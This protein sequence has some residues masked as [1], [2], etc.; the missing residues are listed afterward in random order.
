MGGLSERARSNHSFARLFDMV[1]TNPLPDVEIQ[2]IDISFEVGSGVTPFL[3]ALTAETEEAAGQGAIPTEPSALASVARKSMKTLDQ[4]IARYPTFAPFVLAKARLLENEG[5]D[6][7]SLK[8]LSDSLAKAKTSESSIADYLSLASV[9]ANLFERLSQTDNAL[10]CLSQALN[11][12]EDLAL[13][14]QTNSTDQSALGDSLGTLAATYARLGHGPEACA[15]MQKLYAQRPEDTILPL[16]L[17]AWQVWFGQDAAYEALR[18]RLLDQAEGSDEPSTAERAAKVYCLR[19]STNDVML[20]KAL[21]LATRAVEMG[22][23]NSYQGWF[24]LALGMAEYR[25]GHYAAAE[26]ALVA[27]EPLPDQGQAL[28]CALLGF[29]ALSLIRQGRSA[30]ART[31]LNQAAA[32]MPPV[33]NHGAPPLQGGDLASHDVVVSWL[34]YREA[35]SALEHAAANKP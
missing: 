7:A 15:F 6:E 19:S 12:A 10:A 35:A 27:A 34:A 29:R 24:Q 33:P 14:V 32:Q 23:G 28:R 16:Q 20:A 30:E 11:K 31:L 17:G 8:L 18:D 1:W 2:S 22:N 26:Q 25:S 3:V 5:Q 4:A 21:A 13:R 9:T